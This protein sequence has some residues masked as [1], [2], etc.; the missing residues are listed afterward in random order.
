M[1]EIP[2]WAVVWPAAAV[3]ARYLIDN[4]AIVA[5]KTVLD[6]GC[7]GGVGGIAARRAGA[8]VV[9]AN[10]TDPVALRMAERNAAASGATLRYD[11]HDYTLDPDACPAR[12]VL[13]CDMFYQR[14]EAQA[15]RAACDAF[16]TKGA[17]VIIA[18]GGRPYA[19][20]TG[21]VLVEG[22]AVKVMKDL[23]GVEQRVVSI[24][25]LQRQDA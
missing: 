1:R 25:M 8:A 24:R 21:K 11:L 23:E 22:V 7:G 12:V 3:L 18:D 6:V 19:P 17:T 13:I 20:K 2:Y 4:P 15:M 9:Y 14:T 5:D 10:D 16:V